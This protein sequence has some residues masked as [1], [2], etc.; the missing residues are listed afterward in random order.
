VI[1]T[2]NVVAALVMNEAQPGLYYGS[3]VPLPR[4]LRES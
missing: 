2:A 1:S 3:D 4:K